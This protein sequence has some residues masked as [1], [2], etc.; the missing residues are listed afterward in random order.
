MSSDQ[1]TEYSNLLSQPFIKNHVPISTNIQESIDTT[2]YKIQQCTIQAAIQ[3]IS[4]KKTHKQSYNYKYTP[5]CTALNTGLKKLEHLIKLLK[6]NSITYL[7]HINL[8]ISFI[9]SRAKC[10]LNFLISLDSN[11]IQIWLVHA[12]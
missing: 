7:P 10:N 4:N 11:Q 12:Q 2:W 8:H 1:W 6:S 9:N 5:H 3:K